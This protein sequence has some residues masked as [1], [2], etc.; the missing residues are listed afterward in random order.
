MQ[1]FPLLV[2]VALN[3]KYLIS[4]NKQLQLFSRKCIN[5]F[6]WCLII[7]LRTAGGKFKNVQENC[8]HKIFKYGIVWNFVLRHIII[9][10]C[11]SCHKS[12][13]ALVYTLYRFC[14]FHHLSISYVW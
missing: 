13:N 2:K 9:E 7:A 4:K 11:F 14:S 12:G 1:T 8:I 3:I 5:S 10:K 6:K